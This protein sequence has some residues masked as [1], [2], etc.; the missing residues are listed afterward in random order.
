MTDRT[1]VGLI[2]LLAALPS[3]IWAFSGSGFLTDDWAV[4]AVFDRRGVV[5]ALQTLAFEQPARP[6]AAPYYAVQYLVIGDLPVI[7]SF[8]M[9][10]INAAV[11]A[12]AWWCGRE[13]LP[14]P[15][16]GPSLLVFAV[17]P[18]HATTRLWFVVGTYPLALAIS[19]LALGFL[20]R[21]RP[22]AAAVL[23]VA[24][25]VLYEGSVVLALSAAALWVCV[26]LRERLRPG[27]I[28]V[29]PT[30]VAAGA[31]FLLSPKRDSETGS[32]LFENAD[33]F[34]HGVLGVGVWGGQPLGTIAIVAFLGAVVVAIARQLPS[35]RSDRVE[36]RWIA[37]GAVLC[38][39]SATPYFLSGSIFA[40]S[41]LFD[42]NN[43]VP[44]VGVALAMGATWSLAHRVHQRAAEVL[45]IA[46]L[47][48]FSVLNVD[49]IRTFESAVDRG[50]DVIDA[51]ERTGLQGTGDGAL[52]IVPAQDGSGGVAN[53]VYSGDLSAAMEY[54]LGGDWSGVQLVERTDCAVL[55]E[56][57][58]Q[59]L[60]FDWEREVLDE[61]S[62]ENLAEKCD[63][64]STSG[65]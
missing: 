20:F 52:L 42:R 53:F 17:L 14:R 11:V 33:S 31:S 54:R 56:G 57:S 24:S 49:D 59:V 58:E 28:V 25:V 40:T 4:W 16:L 64:W 47:A 7:Q 46:V 44:A 45:A 41:G 26:S 34:A 3:L 5:D 12:A 39:A 15:V 32:R 65:L 63:R 36:Y 19:L 18:N 60:V 61:V 22:R 35:F 23:L 62:T 13:V 51:L 9:A 37:V 48:W 30:I 21:G 50:E 27:L 10:A 55:A 43:L 38:L 8:V 2:A 1:R 6:L 29:V